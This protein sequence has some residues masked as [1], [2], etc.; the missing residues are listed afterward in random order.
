[1]GRLRRHKRVL[2][3][4]AVVALLGNLLAASAFAPSATAALADDILGPI[5]IC[6]A[7]GAKALPDDGGPGQHAP[8]NHCPACTL[9]AQL[10]L[11]V[12]IVAIAIAFP[13]RTVSKPQPVETRPLAVQFSLGGIGS[14]APP[15]F[16]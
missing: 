6:T 10:A 2:V 14:R 1:M 3:W 16:A 4:L 12:A 9:H 7:N 11:T 13:L 15:L 5:V 8:A